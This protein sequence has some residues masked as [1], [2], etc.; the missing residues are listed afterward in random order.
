MPTRGV[1]R[2]AHDLAPV[3]DGTKVRTPRLEVGDVVYMLEHEGEG[4]FLMWRRGEH[5]TWRRPE[6]P[7]EE[8]FIAWDPA[9]PAPPGAALG[10]WMRVRRENGGQSGWAHGATF[11]CMGPLAGDDNCRN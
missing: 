8:A 3:S 4:E 11:E 6:T 7:E 5:L 1:V 10:H 9:P 2:T